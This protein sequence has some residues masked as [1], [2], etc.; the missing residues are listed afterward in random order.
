M[1][2]GPDRFGS[3]G[4]TVGWQTFER[5]CLAPLFMLSNSGSAANAAV[6]EWRAPSA[7]Q[8]PSFGL[9]AHDFEEALVSYQ[10]AAEARRSPKGVACRRVALLH[11]ARSMQQPRANVT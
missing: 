4:E 6:A 2:A 9:S 7:E 11:V 1:R 3:A 10:Q 5:D 8:A